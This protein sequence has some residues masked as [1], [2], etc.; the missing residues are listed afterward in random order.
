MPCFGV[1]TFFVYGVESILKYNVCQLKKSTE[2]ESIQPLLQDADLI[3]F[4]DSHF[5][6][7]YMEFNHEFVT[8]APKRGNLAHDARTQMRVKEIQNRLKEITFIDPKAHLSNLI[9]ITL[10]YPADSESWELFSKDVKH[11]LDSI[12]KDDYIKMTDYVITIEATKKGV[13][14]AHIL[15]S[16]KAPIRFVDAF[17]FNPQTRKNKRF[18]QIADP[19]FTRLIKKRWKYINTV[20]ACY[21]EKA[22][23]YIFKYVTK[24]FSNV[25]EIY[26]KYKTNGKISDSEWKAM[27]GLYSLVKHNKRAFRVS[28]SYKKAEKI[29]KPVEIHPNFNMYRA[30]GCKLHHSFCEE[31]ESKCY[32]A[33]VTKVAQ[34]RIY[35]PHKW[36]ITGFYNART[37]RE[38]LFSNIQDRDNI[39][40]FEYDNKQEYRKEIWRTPTIEN[41]ELYSNKLKKEIITACQKIA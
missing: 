41:V 18:G 14:H 34:L 27:I 2:K 39:K 36:T 28:R 22:S 3:A 12:R 19:E 13:A 29:Q 32:F 37:L 30:P 11:F 33:L 26:Q 20:E 21:S 8:L 25:R 38:K 40:S 23:Y 6:E 24:G 4:F 9:H 1:G 17:R 5:K 16:V 7:Y 15:M 35:T 10:T 31:C